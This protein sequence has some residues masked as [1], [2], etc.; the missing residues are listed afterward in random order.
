VITPLA[1]IIVMAKK[2]TKEIPSDDE[3]RGKVLQYF[4]DRYRNSSGQRG[5]NG[6]QTKVSIIKSDLKEVLRLLA[7]RNI[8]IRSAISSAGFLS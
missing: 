1:T 6:I 4:Y 5:K 8:F 2:A 3:I 7:Q